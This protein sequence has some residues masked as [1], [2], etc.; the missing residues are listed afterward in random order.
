MACP[1][2]GNL[3]SFGVSFIRGF[4]ALHRYIQGMEK[5]SKNLSPSADSATLRSTCTPPAP[6]KPED[7]F[8][9]EALEK[10]GG[11]PGKKPSNKVVV[12]ALWALRDKMIQDTLKLDE[13][14]EQFN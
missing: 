11:G 4:T 13:F 9:P 12:D 10:M 14:L 2:L 3:S 6:I 1:L 8:S 5:N 7:W